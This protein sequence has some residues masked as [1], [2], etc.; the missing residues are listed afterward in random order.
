MRYIL[1]FLKLLAITTLL[2]LAFLFYTKYNT[3]NRMAIQN[4][5][6][7]CNSDVFITGE[8]TTFGS[9]LTISCSINRVPK[10]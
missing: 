1:K 6:S 7:A 9:K 4:V 8:S 10:T 3:T 2:F 5:L